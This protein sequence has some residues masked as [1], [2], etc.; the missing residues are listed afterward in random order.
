MLYKHLITNELISESTVF[1][2][3][4]N[5]TGA[6]SSVLEQKNHNVIKRDLYTMEE[7]H[8]FFVS[9]L[10]TMFDII[11]TNPPYCL[12]HEFLQRCLDI[13]KPFCL[14]V[15]IQQLSC[16]RALKMVGSSKLHILMLC[17]R[18]S[19]ID[20]NGVNLAMTPTCWVIGNFL[21]FEL[22]PT[23]QFFMYSTKE[24]K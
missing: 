23:H 10:P 3:P 11:I 24:Y 17:P 9:D 7:K 1:L 8:D 12:K 16:T 19:F 14:L 2:E 4:C 13:G 5:G 18:P 22:F 20:K 15:P 21:E 6:I